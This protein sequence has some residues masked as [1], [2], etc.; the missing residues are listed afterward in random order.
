VGVLANH[1]WSFAGEQDRVD[2]N[3]TFIQPF[4]AYA[5]SGGW[6]YTLNTESTYDWIAKQWSVP[7]NFQVQK[8]TK[9]GDQPVSISAGPKYWA[10]NPDSG[11]H[12]WGGRFILT[13]IFP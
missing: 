4:I 9:F 6:T 5:A 12:G 11:P 7:I 8:L 3:S 10:E 13:F 1:I 2:V